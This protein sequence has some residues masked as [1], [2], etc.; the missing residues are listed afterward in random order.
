MFR[1]LGD[2]V[3]IKRTPELSITKGGIIIPET[4]KEK[5]ME[6]TVESFGE[7]VKRVKKGQR[8]LYAKYSGVDIKLREGNYLIIIENDILGII[9]P[10]NK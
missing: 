5:P 10:D 1:P 4:Y 8:V 7:E 2:R 6:G 9:E 3:L